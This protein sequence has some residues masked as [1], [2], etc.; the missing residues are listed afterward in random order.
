MKIYFLILA[1]IFPV[2]TSNGQGTPPSCVITT[3]HSN[4]YYQ[5]GSDIMIR[6]YASGAGGS[7]TAA[8]VEKVELFKDD[9]KL[10]ET[11]SSEAYTFSYLWTDVSAGTYRI[12]AKASA[13]NGLSQVSAGV[14]MTVGTDPVTASGLS[15]NKG[16]YLANINGYNRGDYLSYWNGV[17]AENSCK[18]GSV[19]GMRDYMNWTNA[20]KTYNFAKD[21]HLSFR[22][23][24]I[25]W[26][27]Q[28]PSWITTL[29]PEDFQA[30]VEEYMAAIAARYPLID[31][32]EVLNEN[33]YINTY[34][35][36]E[37]AAGTPYFRAGLGGPGETGYDW[38]IWL[39]EKARY[40][41]PDTKLV[42]NDFE[43]ETNPAGLN[44]ILA[45]VKVLR[46]RGLI[47]G[48]GTQA[49]YFNV[50][51]IY[52]STLKNAL[53]NMARSGVPIYVTELDMK[54]KSNTEDSQLTSYKTAFPEYWNHPAVAGITLWGYV[55]GATWSAGTGL[56]NS[57][58]SERSAMTWLKTFMESQPDVGY[59]F[60]KG[61]VTTKTGEIKVRNIQV[62]PN[63]STD[64]IMISGLQEVSDISIFDMSGKLV[65]RTKSAGK[66]DISGLDNGLYLLRIGDEKTVRIAKMEE[67][68]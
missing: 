35:K 67:I 37:H 65:L 52:A 54:G 23:H 5:E 30:E 2:L 33:M 18:W 10:G 57:N 40:Y 61:S 49:H 32:I 64:Y 3:P 60:G 55:E 17:T 29:S 16:K 62:Y 11:T 34:N 43:L 59:P 42:I 47:D 15:A 46:D 13:D 56:L 41:F 58:G 45:L 4:A 1:L 28:Y 7:Y 24:V 66:V 38:A 8:T 27:S 39:F 50:D 12:T 51:G 48:F 36:E 44:E 53:D 6:V 19:E 26:G 9:I 21:N 63:P 31:Q 25:A 14:I 68:R 20:D 22:Y